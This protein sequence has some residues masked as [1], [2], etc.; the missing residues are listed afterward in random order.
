MRENRGELP[1]ASLVV[2]VVRNGPNQ[3]VWDISSMEISVVSIL[4][5]SKF[6]QLLKVE[7]AGS[8]SE[9]PRSRPTNSRKKGEVVK[10]TM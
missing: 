9:R 6:R 1:D 8:T 10:Q 4:L 7:A 5:S 2:D 3:P